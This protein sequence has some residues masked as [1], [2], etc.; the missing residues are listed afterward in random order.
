MEEFNYDNRKYLN[1]K[2]ID[3]DK[4]KEIYKDYEVINYSVDNDKILMNGFKVAKID[5]NEKDKT[6]ND[7]QGLLDFDT[8]NILSITYF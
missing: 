5:K 3:T 6:I 8:E 1:L 4:V 7:I 2:K